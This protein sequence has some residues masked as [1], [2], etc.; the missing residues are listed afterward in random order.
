MR[1]SGKFHIVATLINYP[2]N[3]GDCSIKV[4]CGVQTSNHYELLPNFST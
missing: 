1:I 4:F 2:N 3:C